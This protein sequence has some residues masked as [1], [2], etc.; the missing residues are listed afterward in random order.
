M[1]PTPEMT[2]EPIFVAEVQRR[3]EAELRKTATGVEAFRT[4]L[5]KSGEPDTVR[6]FYSRAVVWLATKM[7]GNLPTTILPK[8]I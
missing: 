7:A 6:F 4:L 2:I 3:F 5:R 8:P 1:T